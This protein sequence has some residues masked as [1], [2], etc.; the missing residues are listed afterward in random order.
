MGEKEYFYYFT[1]E[2]K[3]RFRYYHYLTQGR[4]I[5]FRIQ[6]EAYVDGK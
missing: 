4:V 1:P 2:R 5:R 3:D 6:Y